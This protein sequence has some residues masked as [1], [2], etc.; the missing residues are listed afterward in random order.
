MK[1]TTR[2][3]TGAAKDRFL[4][5]FFA[6]EPGLEAELARRL[7]AR[8]QATFT[9]LRIRRLTHGRLVSRPRPVEP[10]VPAPHAPVIV[11]APP[12]APISAEP[13]TPSAAAFDPYVFGLVPVFQREGRD[14]LL[15]RL[16]TVAGVEDLRLMARTQQI[17]L[18]EALRRGEAEPA[19]VRT[20]IA[21]AVA[22]R[23]A[24]RRAAAG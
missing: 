12:A 21:D 24:D 16:A 6:A 11:A 22:K 10:V 1:R 8:S 7:A 9:S 5:G 13:V 19:A 2:K 14:G 15:A 17:V 4:A 18:P 23:I 3:L 20:A